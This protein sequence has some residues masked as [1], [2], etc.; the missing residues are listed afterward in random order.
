[1]QLQC[2]IAFSLLLNFA[3][4]SR[5]RPPQPIKTANNFFIKSS[6]NR[7]YNLACL[8]HGE[9]IVTGTGEKLSVIRYV[10]LRDNATGKE[11]RYVPLDETSIS[12][13]QGYFTSAWSPDEEY[14]V[15][16]R[17]RFKGFCIIKSG[18]AFESVEKNQCS[19]FIQI[20]ATNE[21]NLWHE[22]VKWNDD[23]TFI[24]KAGLS[25]DDF[26]FAYNLPKQE[27]T[28]LLPSARSFTA[29][30]SKGKLDIQSR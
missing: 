30:N 3:A 27:L 15:L 8:F 24:F 1:M 7:K 12:S 11:L 25:G 16:P 18:A 4:C 29:E 13:S 2:I 21:T 20:Q 14:L 22:F 23:H 26:N 9:E 6:E 5:A 19:D 10:A 28:A 17:G